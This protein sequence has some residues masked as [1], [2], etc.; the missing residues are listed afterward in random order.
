MMNV[1]LKIVI[2]KSIFILLLIFLF[3]NTILGQKHRDKFIV[4]ANI[5]ILYTLKTY[6]NGTYKYCVWSGIS[7]EEAILDSGTYTIENS[8]ITFKSIKGSDNRF[9]GKSYF[10][11]TFTK[12]RK[13][14]IKRRY[15]YS[16]KKILFCKKIKILL[17]NQDD[18]IE[19]W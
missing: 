9:N 6:K 17:V 8:K 13:K 4:S 15:L 16:E 14:R 3:S 5:D 7:D 12:F 1:E 11:K 19:F 18:T 2:R 10:M